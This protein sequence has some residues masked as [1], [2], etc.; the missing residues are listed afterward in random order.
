MHYAIDHPWNCGGH[1][2]ANI[3]T[4]YRAELGAVHHV[5]KS[6]TEPTHIICDCQSVVRQP[7]RILHYDAQV[8]KGGDHADLWLSIQRET[9]DKPEGYF[10]ITWIPSHVKLEEAEAIEARGGIEQRHLVGNFWADAL[11]KE[12]LRDHPI[13]HEEHAQADYRAF[14]ACM[15]QSWIKAVWTEYFASDEK[16]RG[17]E[18]FPTDD[19]EESVEGGGPDPYEDYEQNLPRLWKR[20]PKRVRAAATPGGCRQPRVASG[21]QPKTAQGCQQYKRA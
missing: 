20:L 5:I 3:Q 12:G 6:A 13:D 21:Q 19:R 16:I 7:Q 15:M 17:I 8:E 10:D 9:R 18:D 4:V 14:I 11:A 2:A 1:V